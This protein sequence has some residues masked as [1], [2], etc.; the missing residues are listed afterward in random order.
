MDF[1]DPRRCPDCRAELD[2]G[3]SCQSCRLDLTSDAARQVWQALQS[4]DA[5]LV[6]AR[7][8]R[9]PPTVQTPPPA[10]VSPVPPPPP[11]G[12]P[13]PPPV[14][15]SAAPPVPSAGVG[16]DDPPTPTPPSTP[17]QPPRPRRRVSVGTVLLALGALSLIVA[18]SIF[19]TVYWGPMGIVGRALVLLAVTGLFGVLAALVTRRRL[20]ASA[21]ALWTVFLGLFSLD[22]LAA[23]DQGLLGLDALPA[24]PVEL[25]WAAVLCGAAV[26]IVRH[27][28]RHLIDDA[29]PVTLVTPSVAAG[30]GAVVAVVRRTGELL[31]SDLELFWVLAVLI[32]GLV[33]FTAA[34]YRLG[35]TVGAVVPA[36]VG[37][38]LA[39]A[40]AVVAVSQAVTHP[41]AR[42]LVLDADGLP[43]LLVSAVVLAASF[44]LRRRAVLSSALAAPAALGMALLVLLPS[45]EGHGIE[46]FAVAAAG[47]LLLGS[48]AGGDSVGRG[49]RWAASV[50]GTLVAAVL[51]FSSLGLVA[52]VALSVTGWGAH[53]LAERLTDLG[54]VPVDGWVP[55]VAAVA[56]AVAGRA[57]RP[58]VAAGLARQIPLVG[59]LLVLLGLWSSVALYE[60]TAL[61][62]TLALLGGALVLAY[63]PLPSPGPRAVLA[64]V[65]AAGAPVAALDAWAACLITWPL[66]A[67][68]LVVL[69][70]TR[71]RGAWAELGSF[72]AAWWTA[73]SV[74]SVLLLLEQPGTV[75]GPVAVTCAGALAGGAALLRGRRGRLGVEIA[76]GVVGVV[77]VV[78]SAVVLAPAE[79]AVVAIAIAAVV[80]VLLLVQPDR[81]WYAA[82][83]VPAALLA[84]LTAPQDGGTQDWGTAVWAWP[85]AALVIVVCGVRT[86]GWLRPLPVGIGS[87]VAIG[88]VVPPSHLLGADDAVRL[89]AVLGASLVVAA[90]G[91][92]AVPRGWGGP[93]AEVAGGLLGG[94]ALALAP[95]WLGVDAHAAAC[96]LA[97]AVALGVGWLSRGRSWYVLVAGAPAVV[98]VLVSAGS[99]GVARWSWPVA[100][101]VL[102]LAAVRCR[103]LVR[104]G[105]AALAA[106]VL[107]GAVVPPLE[108]AGVTGL[109]WGLVVLAAALFLLGVSLLVLGRDRGGDGVE[110]A[111]AL[112]AL[113]ALAGPVFDLLPEEFAILPL[114]LAAGLLGL[115]LT[116]A[117][118]GWYVLG[119][120]GAALL[121]AILTVDADGTAVWI[122]P[123]AA[124]V[125]AAAVART[126]WNEGRQLLAGGA[127]VLLGGTAWPAGRV[128]EL[129][130]ATTTLGVV[131]AGCLVLVVALLVL[132]PPRG[133]HGA[134]AAGGLL[135]L[136]GVVVAGA[137]TGPAHVALL[138]TVAGAV[139]VG[140]SLVE[141]RRP[142]Y[143]TVGIAAL[144]LAYVLRLVASDVGVVEA[145]TLPFGVGLL[146]LGVWV[147]VRPEA[148]RDPRRTL[149]AMG[150]GLLLTLAP[151]LPQALDDPTSLRALLLGAGSLAVMVVG[152]VRRWQAPFVA[153][154][155]VVTLLVLTNVGP[156][157]WGLPRW[158]LIAAAGAV[159]LGAGVTWEQRVR[160]GRAAVRWVGAMR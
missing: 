153:G 100:G 132:R 35:L 48:L 46:G 49:V 133:G 112:L 129:D 50:P 74:I 34:L 82:V 97:A 10:P 124:V 5:W 88:A 55:T 87:A 118:R 128:L 21:E 32:G 156:Y 54:D 53:D 13:L 130:I 1:A 96:L 52:A 94:A 61:V 157:A 19:I 95:F 127:A 41:S 78:Q 116:V 68:L 42:S 14:P 17:Q 38:L 126:P 3:T 47:L 36:G 84:V 62:L 79:F 66:A 148:G 7:T 4:A 113:L 152:I 85:T 90:L 9:V 72:A 139:A 20:R 37:G 142:W 146:G 30:L 115:G 121:A 44:V 131:V 65:V 81:G 83:A 106:L 155:V 31:D 75:V 137:Q 120:A 56:L 151:S 101:L 63:V 135:V 25:A 134:E 125:I 45:A 89:W 67:A 136:A 143:R 58:R 145:Y 159:M 33:V 108:L 24:A 150:P 138:L 27:G 149:V 123:L 12:E 60:P 6:L 77:G 11:V 59:V 102:A 110:G 92:L 144:A 23:R 57:L 29:V 71:G 40:A 16:S 99:W 39:S 158:V 111:G 43:L 80:A 18:A 70:A 117:R 51:A 141:R 98:A 119:A 26:L 2:G 147:T 105:V 109:A 22:W 15:V 64:G 140:L 73:A 76:A 114:V 104:A 122:W 28:R 154:A 69:V 107:G 103:G 160:D 86:T 91:A 8:H 93:G